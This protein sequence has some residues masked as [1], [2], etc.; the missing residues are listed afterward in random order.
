M[1]RINKLVISLWFFM[2]CLSQ[3]QAQI[4]DGTFSFIGEEIVT[5]D[6]LLT[7]IGG[8]PF[9]GTTVEV[10]LSYGFIEVVST[11]NEYTNV[12]ALTLEKDQVSAVV[13]EQ[14]QLTAAFSPVE[15]DNPMLSWHSSD[16]LVVAVKDGVVSAL[17]EGEATVTV[18]SA[19]GLFA[20]QCEVTV[21]SDPT[22]I[23]ELNGGNRIYPTV[24][25]DY[26][27]ADLQ[28]AET[29]YIINVS[30]KVCE[31]VRC[32]AGQNTI[33]MQAYPIGVYFI[34]MDSKVVK[35]IKR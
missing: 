2:A 9:E 8:Q 32:Q 30:G 28:Q 24:I 20:D 17:Q 13:G 27:Y 23:E 15:V 19:S 6:I 29:I 3:A 33:S 26:L 14:L 31:K 11:A 35:V 10:P 22:G 21:K 34:R 12:L 25:E 16:P 4:L 1:E 18:V 5:S 7:S